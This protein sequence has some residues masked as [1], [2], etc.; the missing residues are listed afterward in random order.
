MEYIFETESLRVRKFEI[1]DVKCLY[2]KHLEV[3][4]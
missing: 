2:E 1:E 3:C 4:E